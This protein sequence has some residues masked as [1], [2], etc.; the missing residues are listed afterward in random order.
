MTTTSA[1]DNSNKERV[2]IFER[3]CATASNRPAR[4]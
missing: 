4:R 2:Y 1:A 3:R